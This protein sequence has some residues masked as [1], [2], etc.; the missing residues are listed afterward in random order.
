MSA[1]ETKILPDSRVEPPRIAT[2][3][4]VLPESRAREIKGRIFTA[5]GVWIPIFCA[6]CGVGVGLV[7]EEGMTFVFWLC[8]KCEE[9]HGEVAGMMRMP[10]EVF[11][12]KLKQ[13]Q[14]AH[15]GYYPTQEELAKVLEE[16]ASPLATLLKQGR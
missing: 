4:D 1:D 5:N 12:E 3:A 6:N 7:P 9:T 15:F 11:W 13:E 10:D 2:P 16:D 14:L 8:R